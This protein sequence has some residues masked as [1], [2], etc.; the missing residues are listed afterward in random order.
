MSEEE[1]RLTDHYYTESEINDKVTILNSKID[2][3]ANKNHQSQSNDYG[4]GNA[5]YYGHLRLSNSIDSES[6]INDG[7]AATPYA[8]KRAYDKG[9]NVNTRLTTIKNNIKQGNNNWQSMN[10]NSANFRGTESCYYLVRNGWCFLNVYAT[11]NG[12]Y[13]SPPMYLVS[14]ND[15]LG[16]TTDFLEGAA[17]VVGTNT[18]QYNEGH[19]AG[20]Y[21]G[22]IQV[23]RTNANPNF[24]Y[25]IR[26]F[27]QVNLFDG[28]LIFGTLAYPKRNY[29]SSLE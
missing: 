23:V 25:E 9:D 29:N 26:F 18:S 28:D 12:S 27:S 1:V 17:Q 8:I 7:V 6:G 16:P 3:K 5:G 4:I 21:H 2:Q 14:M 24:P 19:A 15:N 20:R 13:Y 22:T 11:I 10:L